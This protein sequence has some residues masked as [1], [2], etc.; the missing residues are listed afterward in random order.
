MIAPDAVL[1][2]ADDSAQYV[3]RAALKLLLG[4][5]SFPI[6]PKGK[7]CI[8]LGASTGGFTQVLLERGA[9]H[10]TAIDV[11]HGQ[12]VARIAADPRV[13]VKEGLNARSL[14]QDDVPD[15]TALIVSDLSFISL[16]LALPPI[17]SLARPEQN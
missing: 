11:G 3:S 5:Q 13:T 6:D 17:L 9:A 1:T 4:F 2:L 8:D 12:M 10:V 14:T 16:R 7:S 15:D